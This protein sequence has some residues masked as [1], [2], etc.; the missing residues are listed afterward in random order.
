MTAS[1]DQHREH[2]QDDDLEEAQV[3]EEGEHAESLD[4]PPTWGRLRPR[5]LT[6]AVDQHREHAQDDD[7][8]EA[9]VVEEGEHAESLDRP[10]EGCR[11]R[12]VNSPGIPAWRGASRS[13]GARRC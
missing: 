9:Q 6:A 3:V 4:R 1:I 2:A 13:A 11:S 10:P 5:G 8:E 7:L 12:G